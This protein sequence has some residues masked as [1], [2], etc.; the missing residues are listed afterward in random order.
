MAYVSRFLKGAWLADPP[1]AF[2]AS[3]Y[4][5]QAFAGER[6][7]LVGDAGLFIDPMS[8]EGV[9]KAMASAITGAVVVNTVLQRPALRHHAI[10]FYE[11]SQQHTYDS[12]Y[13]Q[14]VQYYQEERRWVDHAFWH[15]RATIQI[16]RPSQVNLT[17]PDARS[18]LSHPQ[19]VSSLCLAP[20]VSI[21][22]RAVIEGRYI[23]LRE[24]VCSPHHP[25]G[26]RFL[27]G[28][29]VPTLLRLVQTYG[30]IADVIATYV[31][32]TAGRHCPPEQVRQ[33]LARLCHEGVLA[34]GEPNGSR[35]D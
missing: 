34:A 30:T 25:R 26:L 27:Q 18:S 3:L 31:N 23:E 10:G 8:S 35:S 24:V 21:A 20:G 33:T 19:S 22:Q 16:A 15:R 7:L 2:D 14:A 28:V 6:F 11:E 9:H 29:S 13:R 12:H 17:A 32:S 5:A 1:R 4:T